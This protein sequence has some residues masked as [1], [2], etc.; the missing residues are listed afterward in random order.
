MA[1]AEKWAVVSRNRALEHQKRTVQEQKGA[2]CASRHTEADG[3]SFL[4]SG[5][6]F[7]QIT[8]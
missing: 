1:E 7:V 6:I 5:M 3:H 2:C 8:K 4:L